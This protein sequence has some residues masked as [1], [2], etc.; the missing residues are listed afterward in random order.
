MRSSNAL[1]V[2]HTEGSK[3]PFRNRTVENGEPAHAHG[4]GRLPRR[5]GL[6]LVDAV[7]QR[8]QVP[9]LNEQGEVMICRHWRGWTSDENA[10]TYER[11]LQDTIIPGI[12]ARA[13]SGLRHV[14]LMRRELD[15]E[16]EFS[17][18]MWFDDLEAVKAFVGHDVE[19]AHIPAAAREVLSRFDERAV[20]YHVFDRREQGD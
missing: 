14:D 16:V 18:M 17:T 2:V 1:A 3:K 4:F 19:A 5:E 8:S 12:E 9:G 15:C 13:I 10:A 7:P 11:L 6:V 20:H